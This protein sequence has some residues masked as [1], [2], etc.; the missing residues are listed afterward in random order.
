MK[1]SETEPI[2]DYECVVCGKSFVLSVVRMRCLVIH[3]AGTCCHEYETEVVRTRLA[4]RSKD[5]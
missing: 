1:K 3:P 5:A 4:E 2:R